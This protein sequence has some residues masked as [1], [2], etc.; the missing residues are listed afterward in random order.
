MSFIQIVLLITALGNV[1]A[2]EGYAQPALEKRVSLNVR[3]QEVE[4][5]FRE[6]E[7][8]TDVRFVFSRS[9]IRADR[10]VSIR[11]KNQ[12][13]YKVL[14]EVLTPLDLKYRASE[15][16]VII[17]RVEKE[18]ELINSIDPVHEQ[19]IFDRTIRG[20]VT[21]ENGEGLPGVSVVLKGTQKGTISDINGGYEL[22]VPEGENNLIFSFVGY[23]TQEV[24]LGGKTQVDISMKVDEKSLDE[25]VVIG[26]GTVKKEN[27]TG[28]ISRLSAESISNRANT[29]LSE[30]FAGQVS[31]I[32]AKQLSARPGAQLD[33]VIRG[34]NSLSAASSPL[35]VVDG[36]PGTIENIN[37]N[38]IES[39]EV[40]KDAASTAI[41]GARGGNGVILVTTKQGKT[42]RPSIS[43]NS[44]Y[45]MQ[46][47][48]KLI[49]MMNRDEFI[50]YS[51]WGKN[52]AYMQLGGSLNDPMS[53]RPARLQYPKTWENPTT[54][55]DVNWQKAVLQTAPVSSHQLSVSGGNDNATY[56]V[57]GHHLRQ[58][59]IVKYTHFNQTNFRVNTTFRL[60]KNLRAG[61]NI[62][63]SFSTTNNPDAEGHGS[64]YHRALAM[65]PIVP[66][67]MHTQN[68]GFVEG[69]FGNF[70]NPLETLRQTRQNTKKNS[71]SN[72][73]WLEYDFLNKLKIRSQLG[74]NYF[75]TTSDYFRPSD[76]NQGISRGSYSEATSRHI[77]WQNTADYSISPFSGLDINLLL[78]QSLES[79]KAQSSSITASNFPN[80]LVPTLNAASQI[81]SA[82]TFESENSMA[83][84]FGRAS[85]NFK[86]K[87]LVTF[88]VRRDGSSRFGRE[89][90]WGWFPSLSA[91]W[92]LDREGFLKDMHFIDLLKIR[93]SVGQGGSDNIGDYSS[94]SLLGVSNYSLNGSVVNGLVPSTFGNPF[95][96]WEKVVSRDVGI[97]FNTFRN[98]LQLSINLYS[99]ITSDMLFN[100][101]VSP[102]TGFS[103]MLVNL[104]KVR[105]RGFEVDIT[106]VNLSGAK[107]KWE[108]KINISSNRNKILKMDDADSPIRIPGY[109][110][111][112]TYVSTIGGPI[113]S[114]YGFKTNGV[115]QESDFDSEGNPLVAVLRGQIKG[116]E[117]VVDI[118]NDGVINE[119]DRVR[120]GDSQSDFSWGFNNSFRY[121]DFDLSFLI[122][123]SHGAM[124]FVPNQVYISFGQVQGMNSTSNWVRSWKPET[125]PNGENPFPLT[126]VDMSWDGKTPLSYSIGGAIPFSTDRY[127]HDASFIRLKNVSLGY[128][129]SPSVL[130][131]IGISSARI[132]LMADNVH[133]WTKYP[134]VNPEA[135][136]L[137]G[138]NDDGAPGE[139][140]DPLKNGTDWGAYPLMRKYSLGINLKF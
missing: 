32:S 62:A 131:K 73:I 43:V 3:N 55:P 61:L 108:S 1:H 89:N 50:A 39:I 99:N 94:I 16:L 78:G 14:D 88:N 107:L 100:R 111:G 22:V 125:Y 21:D 48:N 115:L 95:L 79:R 128:S 27:V 103:S 68:N 86:D 25:V 34:Q 42:G 6:I 75:N 56:M 101:P 140:A 33:I 51:I 59:G 139:V 126:D 23:V 52:I 31:G 64:A 8:R 124:L 81:N 30:S 45:G 84:I 18:G 138:R 74:Y 70:I 116:N 135:N 123:G 9:L 53:M 26:Y 11:V 57:S 104:G 93:A 37:P 91:G 132:F 113:G 67:N 136:G 98:R 20:V 19:I 17:S 5:V 58:D 72:N 127:F 134:G 92:K 54:L 41:Y 102:M 106:T 47:A 60:Q 119:S 35:Y 63:P 12:A 117:R 137:S 4:S 29:T 114:F 87:Y 65:P 118:N 76:V 36:I 109:F 24:V 13:L 15:N 49:E 38:D 83:S 121:G 44:Y 77:V 82:T 129:F 28:A 120:L 97:D 2:I 110:G 122:H 133:T 105:N 69:A 112:N 80:D 130:R 96:G 40:L 90:K 10:K 71:I 7:Q 46:E 66:L 85:F